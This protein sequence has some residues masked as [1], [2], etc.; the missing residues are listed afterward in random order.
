VFIP[1]SEEIEE[2]F[3]EY[4]LTL[5]MDFFLAFRLYVYPPFMVFG[6]SGAAFGPLNTASLSPPVDVNGGGFE[7]VGLS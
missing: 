2:D 1:N 4:R 7:F 3:P 6:G 5:R